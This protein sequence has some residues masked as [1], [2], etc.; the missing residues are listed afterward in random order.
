MPVPDEVVDRGVSTLPAP[1][2]F[3]VLIPLSI[4]FFTHFSCRQGWLLW[5][6]AGVRRVRHVRRVRQ[7]RCG[8][9]FQPPMGKSFRSHCRSPPGQAGS[10]TRI[11]PSPLLD[12]SVLAIGPTNRDRAK[13]RSAMKGPGSYSS[14]P[15][16]HMWQAHYRPAHL[17]A[18]RQS[19][20]A[21]QGN[22][23]SNT[24]RFN[25]SGEECVHC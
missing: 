11:S 19:D 17:N 23:H 2:F 20:R 7:V 1:I 12:G 4:Y 21:K 16:L 24:A 3:R 9:V 15:R 13:A 25:S 5:R 8:G 6:A 10:R 22:A 18:R 14:M